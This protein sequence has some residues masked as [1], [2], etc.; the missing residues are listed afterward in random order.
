MKRKKRLKKG[1]ESLKEQI[2]IHKEKKKKAEEVDM[3]ELVGYY[4]KEILSKEKA[5]KEKKELLDK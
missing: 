5:M 2:K 4:E 1:I 3:P